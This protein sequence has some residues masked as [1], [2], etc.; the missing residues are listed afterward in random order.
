[1]PQVHFR[2]NV[3]LKSIIG[4]DLITD[5]NIAVLELVKNSFDA[6]SRKV[7]IHFLNTLDNNDSQV[8]EDAAVGPGTKS[9]VKKKQD[10]APTYSKVIIKDTGIGMNEAD[11]KDKWLNIA[12]SE[13]KQK[14]EEF[15]RLMAGN[16][17]VGRFSCDRLGQYL[18]IYTR[19]KGDD[20]LHL[21]IN[22]KDFEV[23]N[24]INLDIQ[25]II[26]NAD[27][28]PDREFEAI[29]GYKPFEKGT[30]LEI[31]RLRENW[32][33]AKIIGLKRQ[34]EK[35]IN[36]NQAFKRN[37]F[38]IEIIAPEYNAADR[39]KE[40]Y[41]RINGPVK[42]KIFEK[43]NFRATSIESEIDAEG[44]FITTFLQDRGNEIFTLVEKNPFPLL[45]N[46]KISIYYLNTYAKIYFAKQTGIRSVDFGSISLFINGFRIP[47]YGDEG[48]DWLGLEQ[49]KGQGYNRY[50]GTREIVGRIEVNDENDQFKIISSRAGVVNSP[51]FSQLTSTSKPFGYFYKCF[52]RIER[53]VVEGIKWDSIDEPEKGLEEK[54]N[55]PSWKESNEKYVEDQLSRNKRVLSVIKNIIDVRSGDIVELNV[56]GDF[57]LEIIEE[58]IATAKEQLDKL[59]QEIESKNLSPDELDKFIERLEKQR[60]ELASFSTTLQ[61]YDQVPKRELR[62]FEKIR[63][64]YEDRYSKL[65]LEK[66]QL[67]E[68][69]R[70]E[71]EERLRLEAE[72]EAERRESLFNK[73]LAGTNIKEVVSLQHHIDRAAEKIN[74]NVSDLITGINN[75]A[76]KSALLKLV[77]RISL[78]SKKISSVVQFVTN[79]NFNVKATSIKND[80]NRFVED[81][82]VN[83]HQEYEH[84]KLNR[85]LL[86]VELESDDKPFV[87]SFRPIEVVMIIDNLFSNAVRAKAKNAV[88]KLRT[89]KN[90]SFEISFRDDGNGI[91]N[92]ILPR[93]FNMGFTTTEGSGIGLYHV[94]QLVEKLGGNI[95]VNNKLP[96][97]VQ[98]KITI[99]GNAS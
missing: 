53:F 2:T 4:K 54:V 88:I 29:T 62:E 87:T 1:M 56:N 49:R 67:E 34:L 30:I 86:K 28:I 59:Y 83:V 26:L 89:T 64:D 69:V 61:E 65:L 55:K 23:E 48:D 27:P 95:E 25:K 98:F 14:R 20:I 15:G 5:D 11:L 42:N 43:L 47:P 80:L 97:G 72:L 99:P 16:K 92:D 32:N 3:L 84:L 10:P 39:G 6:N 38:E 75:D 63:K 70:K 7:E 85:Q 71:E 18:D 76:S 81:Y 9:I 82:I 8:M 51:T 78:E 17:G 22:W 93:I 36:P 57:V 31:S 41:E 12:Y 24:E 40:E 90:G 52:R 50:L 21:R 74:K 60:N 45:R 35:L 96:K 68:K 19:K 79:A 46:I 73:R 77:N 13:K 66:Q 58:N 33:G 94:N 37:S 91:K 44:E